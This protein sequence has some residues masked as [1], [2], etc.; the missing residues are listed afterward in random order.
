[1]KSQRLR[2][3]PLRVRIADKSVLTIEIGLD[4]LKT[5]ADN[6]PI[7]HAHRVSDIDQLAK[8]IVVILAN[9]EDEQ[10]FTPI[11]RAIDDAIEQAYEDG[12]HCFEE[13][14]AEVEP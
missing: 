8:E 13:L 2:D 6:G 14:D 5:V 11:M 9:D 7:G 4:T 3:V 10:G 12:S 1:M